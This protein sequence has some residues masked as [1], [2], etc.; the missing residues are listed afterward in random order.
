[1]SAPQ[2]L[3]P[4]PEPVF[5]GYTQEAL[6]TKAPSP[7]AGHPESDGLKKKKRGYAAQAYE[8]GAG[9][10]SS[11]GGQMQGGAQ[12]QQ[13]QGPAYN[14]GYAAQPDPQIPYGAPYYGSQS[15][16]VNPGAQAPAFGGPTPYSGIGYQP[17]NPGNSNINASADLAGIT[18]SMGQMGINN[19]QPGIQ[20]LVPQATR[21]LVLN[22]LYPTDLLSQPFNVGELDM[23]PP[24]I[25]LP[26]N[27]SGIYLKKISSSNPTY[28]QV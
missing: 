9:A 11:L 1:M 15:L 5:P 18:Q 27:V 3:P 8:F 17:P 19:D 10:N 7:T 20:K 25:I 23:P 2:N 21:P 16:P 22:Q 26:P 12:F 24:P 13:P 4:N 14:G 6:S 28:S